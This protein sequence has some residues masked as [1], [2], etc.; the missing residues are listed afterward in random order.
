[1]YKTLSNSSLKKNNEILLDVS[2]AKRILFYTFVYVT[3]FDNQTAF[4]SIYVYIVIS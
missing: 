2:V 1:M 3:Y 4:K